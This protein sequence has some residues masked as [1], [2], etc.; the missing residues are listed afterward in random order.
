[1][2]YFLD[3][4]QGKAAVAAASTP[5]GS[6]AT[7][8]PEAK[9]ASTTHSVAAEPLLQWLRKALPHLPEATLRSYSRVLAD[10]GYD[11][12]NLLP[13]L[14]LEDIPSIPKGY[15]RAIIH[16]AKASSKNDENKR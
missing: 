1:M 5:T 11:H 16:A 6:L 8:I 3:I 9:A 4:K 15:G 7:T 10:A 2:Q 13:H 12:P 14:H